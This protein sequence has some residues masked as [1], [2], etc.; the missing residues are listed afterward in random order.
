MCCGLLFDF[1]SSTSGDVFL[2]PRLEFP[3]SAPCSLL[4]CQ[5]KARPG[6][7]VPSSER[8]IRKLAV[9]KVFMALFWLSFYMTLIWPSASG[10]CATHGCLLE[11]IVIL[12][13]HLNS[14]SFCSQRCSKPNTVKQGWW[15]IHILYLSKII[16]NPFTQVKGSAGL[17]MYSRGKVHLMIV[18]QKWK[19]FQQL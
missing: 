2:S 6:D 15:S 7:H 10:S 8:N 16:L 12:T 9:G 5:W 17:E 11:T 1:P 13:S 14:W 19:C 3:V 4:F 18:L